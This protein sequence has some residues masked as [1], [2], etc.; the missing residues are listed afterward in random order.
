MSFLEGQNEL[1]TK[2]KS[3]NHCLL[4]NQRILEKN[5]FV[6]ATVSGERQIGKSMY[7]IL[8]LYDMYGNWEEV[9]KHI[10]YSIGDLMN[11]LIRA[12][13]TGLRDVLIGVDDAGI[14]FGANQWSV[15]REGVVL[16]SGVFDTIGTVVKG[17]IFTMPNRNNLIKNIRIGEAIVDIRIR[18]GQHKYDR[19]AEAYTHTKSPKDQ[20]IVKKIFIDKYDV[21]IPLLIYERYAKLRDSYSKDTLQRMQNY[22]QGESTGIFI[23]GSRKYTALEVDED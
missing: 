6:M 2:A 5:S 13:S 19:L 12:R 1:I 18:Q 10:F 11:Y 17:C 14:Y 9:F 4:L 8:C 22:L 20:D 21:R 7:M 16:M 3:R 15:D 23:K